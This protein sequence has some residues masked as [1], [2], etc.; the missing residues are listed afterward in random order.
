[1]GFFQQVSGPF[2]LDSMGGEGKSG[3]RILDTYIK[4]FP[5]EYHSQAAIEIMLEMRAAGLRAEEVETLTIHTFKAGVEII[6]DRE[7]WRP[8]TRETADHSLPYCAAAALFDGDISPAQFRPERIAD[9]AIQSFLDRVQVMEDPA[10]TAR[11]PDGI[12]TRIEVRLKDGTRREMRRDYALG[13]PRNPM[14][15]ALVEAKFRRQAES[16][17]SARQQERLLKGLWH[18]EEIQDLGALLREAVV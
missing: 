6:A 4:H 13:H 5:A 14:P 15:D 1:M 7:K 3:Y 18:L 11:Y 16:L 17:L 9:P 8:R 10:L 12:P 2:T